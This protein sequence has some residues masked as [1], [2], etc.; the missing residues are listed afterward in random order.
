MKQVK[1]L[2]R[3]KRLSVDFG[4]GFRLPYMALDSDPKFRG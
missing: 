1:K 4:D 2:L 3:I